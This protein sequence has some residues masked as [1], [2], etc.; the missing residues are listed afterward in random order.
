ML[1]AAALALVAPLAGALRR[2]VRAPA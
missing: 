2:R 1:I